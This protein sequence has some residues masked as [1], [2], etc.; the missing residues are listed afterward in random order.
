VQI[1]DM[2]CF[3]LQNGLGSHVWL[4]CLDP[5]SPFQRFQH[6]Q[7]PLQSNGRLFS[8][9]SEF[10]LTSDGAP[11]PPGHDSYVTDIDAARKGLFSAKG[12]LR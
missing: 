8:L 7:V 5:L 2:I 10:R 4:L 11:P 3:L 12:L 9:K 1:N 6:V